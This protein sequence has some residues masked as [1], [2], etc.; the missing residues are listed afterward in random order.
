MQVVQERNRR[1][2]MIDDATNGKP[3]SASLW[4]CPQ[5]HDNLQEAADE[6]Q[7]GSCGLVVQMDMG[8]AMFSDEANSHGE[9][10]P[11][12]TEA[13]VANIRNKGI[14]PAL[15]LL[16]PGQSSR[17]GRLI[18][19]PERA[20]IVELTDPKRRSRI[21]DFG[22]GYGGV[23]RHLAKSFDEVYALDGSSHRLRVLS[24][25]MTDGGIEN[26]VPV[27][28][29]DVLNLPF[30]DGSLD[31]V[32]LVGVFEYL[33]TGMPGLSLNE[34][35][36]R[37]LAEFRRV[38]RP[39]GRLIIGTHNRFGWPYLLGK[40]D[41][42]GYPFRQ[43]LPRPVEHLTASLAGR[44]ACRLTY[45]TPA[46][47]RRLAARHFSKIDTYWPWPSYQVPRILVPYQSGQRQMQDFLAENYK[48]GKGAALQALA[49]LGM[50]WKVI[51][52]FYVVCEAN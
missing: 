32:V 6:L 43:V 35:H 3:A 10:S 29:Q 33:P 44:A 52:S 22:C 25:I 5:C 39:G 14:E 27:F 7:C 31:V 13:F 1:S 30:Q 28:H 11:S 26:I 4:R 41:H 12:E 34:A 20:N 50:L 24:A 9:L 2:T 8:I 46:G 17:I 38:L 36:D 37:C 15:K 48:G 18:L 42:G 16:D 23:S 49:K 51:P 40:K 21:V 19:A 47:L 45:H